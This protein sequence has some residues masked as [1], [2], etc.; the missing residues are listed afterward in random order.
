MTVTDD[1]IRHYIRVRL[2]GPEKVIADMRREFPSPT[3]VALAR[4]N[5]LRPVSNATINRELMYLRQDYALNVHEIGPGPMMPK[6][7]ERIRENFFDRAD[8]E[9][10]TVNLPE[11]LQDFYLDGAISPDG[12]KAR[13]HP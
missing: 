8:F 6:L 7:K 1:I 2:N 5:R 12:A 13:Y 3:A 4:T 9:I 10:I 11:D